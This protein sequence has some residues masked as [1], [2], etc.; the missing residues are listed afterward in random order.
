MPQWLRDAINP[1]KKED[2]GKVIE[3]TEEELITEPSTEVTTTT[4]TATTVK[5]TE[6]EITL[7][8]ND[9]IFDLDDIDF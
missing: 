7:K 5:A 4:T 3:L 8:A 6:P 9:I 1:P 2:K